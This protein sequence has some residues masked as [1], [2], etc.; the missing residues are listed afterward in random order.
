M[1]LNHE[2]QLDG[3]LLEDTKMYKKVVGKFIYLVIMGQIFDELSASIGI[4]LGLLS[5]IEFVV[6]LRYMKGSLGKG[7]V[8]VSHG[9]LNIVDYLDVDWA[10]SP[11]E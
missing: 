3:E 4:L 8:S 1:P 10:G 6:C 7:V 11:D 5:E 9:H 2:L